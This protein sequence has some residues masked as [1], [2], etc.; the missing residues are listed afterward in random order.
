MIMIIKL[1]VICM[2]HLPILKVRKQLY[3]HPYNSN[4]QVIG[5]ET[6]KWH[7][8]EMLKKKPILF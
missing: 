6:L 2:R 4:K 3:I 1:I 5:G 8:E 7:K